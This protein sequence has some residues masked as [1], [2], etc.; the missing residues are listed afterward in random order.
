MNEY[1]YIT[2]S[3][4]NFDKGAARHVST[5]NNK[6]IRW[7]MRDKSSATAVVLLDKSGGNEVVPLIDY[8]VIRL[9]ISSDIFSHT[10]DDQVKKICIFAMEYLQN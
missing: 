9:F 4:P 1:Q 6:V 10:R 3:L 7:M 2:T 8:S 5:T